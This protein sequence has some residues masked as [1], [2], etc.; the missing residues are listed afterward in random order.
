M[1]IIYMDLDKDSKLVKQKNATKFLNPVRQYKLKFVNCKTSQNRI[2]YY[3]SHVNNS[4]KF[5]DNPLI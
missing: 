4:S 5:Q 3:D 2:P 1:D